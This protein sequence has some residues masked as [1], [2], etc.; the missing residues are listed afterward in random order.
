YAEAS[1]QL[2]SQ[3][4]WD[5]RGRNT[6]NFGDPIDDSSLVTKGYFDNT[7]GPEMDAKVAAAAAWA[8]ASANSAAASAQS[9]ED[10]ETSKEASEAIL[11]EFKKRYQGAHPTDPATRYDGSPLQVGDLYYNST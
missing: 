10:S 3:G 7:Y 9:A 8:N 6:I 4:V 1:V 5:G 2:D 11:D